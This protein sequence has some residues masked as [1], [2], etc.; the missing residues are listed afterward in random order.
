MSQLH[1]RRPL[2]IKLTALFF[3]IAAIVETLRI[4]YAQ[5]LSV[6]PLLTMNQLI[7]SSC[8]PALYYCFALGLWRLL[9]IVRLI[10]I[11]YL[12]YFPL[13]HF[14][15]ILF[16]IGTLTEITRDIF[17]HGYKAYMDLDLFLSITFLGLILL[18]CV[19]ICFLFK[20]R[21]FFRVSRY[22]RLSL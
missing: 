13:A 12:A 15:L 7:L 5:T 11:V 3:L 16:R 19:M 2:S 8:L 14:K 22:G 4:V 17:R 9:N 21:S 6:I 1:L 10:V 20:R 18:N